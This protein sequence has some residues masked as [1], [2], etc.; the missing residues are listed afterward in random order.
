[1]VGLTN[2]ELAG[3]FFPPLVILHH[4]EH[5]CMHTFTASSTGRNR[6]QPFS[7]VPSTP[8]KKG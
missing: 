4:V 5:F 7:L 2:F 1:M 6:S 8:N 3:F